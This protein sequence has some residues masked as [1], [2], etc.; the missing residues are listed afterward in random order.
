MSI[1]LVTNYQQTILYAAISK[2][3]SL[4]IQV[5]AKITRTLPKQD[6]HVSTQLK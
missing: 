5:A 4:G 2:V 6:T 1:C 3:P